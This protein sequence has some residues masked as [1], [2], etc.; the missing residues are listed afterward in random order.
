MGIEPGRKDGGR[1]AL[2]VGIGREV[3]FTLR[4]GSVG[5]WA[6]GHPSKT[7]S[8][9]ACCIGKDSTGSCGHL[10]CVRLKVS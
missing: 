8:E 6:A 3:F 5:E 4:A 2:A 10:V 1:G 7:V 9:I